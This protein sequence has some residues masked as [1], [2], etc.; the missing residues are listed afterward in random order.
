MFRRVVNPLLRNMDG[1]FTK[2]VDPLLRAVAK[3]WLFSE[4]APYRMFCWVLNSCLYVFS[5]Y[6]RPHQLD[7]HANLTNVNF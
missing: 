1:A 7:Q 2:I 4:R 5:S 6:L 3:Y